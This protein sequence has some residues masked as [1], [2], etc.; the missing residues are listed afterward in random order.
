[1]FKSVRLF[2]LLMVLILISVLVSS[3]GLAAG[4]KNC[5]PQQ[6]PVAIANQF[7]DR[8]QAGYQTANIPLIVSL[9]N[10]PV[11]M[12]DVT[13]DLNQF[14]TAESSQAELEAAFL[15]LT[16]IKCDF[17]DRQITAEGDMIMIRTRRVVT[18]NEIPIVANCLLLL[19][20]QRPFTHRQPWDYVIM[21]QIILK[22]EY[23]PKPETGSEQDNTNNNGQE[24][25]NRKK[26]RLVW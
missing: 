2:V 20:L 26:H 14:Y 3:A 4:E 9:Y 13:R 6:D 7:L 15:G 10:D 12:V 17:L 5:W 24:T 1:M 23:L 16:G 25:W 21:N 22:E 8:L 18:A 11:V 19:V